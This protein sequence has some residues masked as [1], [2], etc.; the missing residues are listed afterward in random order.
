[1][2]PFQVTSTGETVYYSYHSSGEDN[3]VHIAWVGPQGLYYRLRF[4][5]GIWSKA[6][7]IDPSGVGGMGSSANPDGSTDLLWL[8]I[9]DPLSDHRLIYQHILL[10]ESGNS[11]ISQG[12]DIPPNLHQPTLSLSYRLEVTGN[13]GEFQVDLNG[14]PILTSSSSTVGWEHHW[15]DVSSWAGQTVTVTLSTE[16]TFKG[17]HVTVLV[18]EVSLGEWLTPVIS[19]ISPSHLPDF[20]NAVITISGENFLQGATVR[21]DES[22]TLATV[23]IDEHTLTAVIPLG[24]SLGWHDVWVLNPGGQA[25]LVTGG[26]QLGTTVN[27]PVVRKPAAT[28]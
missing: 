17:G 19:T 7:P 23:W 16:G 13:A 9:P 10:P 12:I 24:V 15:I 27:L 6:F 14:T 25:A 8:N 11:T 28:P 26:L 2:P 5:D 3:R 1:M 22:T 18:D 21:L 4:A 20:A